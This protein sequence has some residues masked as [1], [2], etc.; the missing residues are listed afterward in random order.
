MSSFLAYYFYQTNCTTAV[1]WWSLE[2]E[3][4][5]GLLQTPLAE[6]HLFAMHVASCISLSARSVRLQRCSWS[7]PLWLWLRSSTLESEWE[8]ATQLQ[9]SVEAGACYVTQAWPW[10]VKWRR[11]FNPSCE[12]LI[13]QLIAAY[14]VDTVLVCN[15]YNTVHTPPTRIRL[16]TWKEIKT[17][18]YRSVCVCLYIHA[19]MYT[20]KRWRV[21]YYK[22]C[23]TQ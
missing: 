22:E 6:N 17:I 7:W 5:P 18:I 14:L 13:Q 8:L 9:F 10:V 21:G 23:V 2:S 20:A 4:R 12:V 19:C 3:L 15:Y 16:Y 1:I 11:Y